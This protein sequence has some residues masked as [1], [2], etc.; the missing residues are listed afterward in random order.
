MIRYGL[1]RKGL[2]TASPS[3]VN[4]LSGDTIWESLDQGATFAPRV[5]GIPGH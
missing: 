3:H 5:S 2:L 1:F 4:V